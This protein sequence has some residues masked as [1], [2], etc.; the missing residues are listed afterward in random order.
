MNRIKRWTAFAAALLLLLPGSRGLAEVTAERKEDQ[1]H[2]VTEITWKD[3]QGNPASGPDGYTTVR[4][5]YDHNKTTEKYFD[6]DGFPYEMPGGYYGLAVT[7]D[8]FL[9]IVEYLGINGKLT[10]TRMGYAKTETRTFSFGPERYVLYYGEDGR[11]V[12][13]PSLGY[14]Q[15]ET[16]AT[17][18]T[19]TGR[20]YKDEKGNRVDIPAGYAAML[21]KM[22]RSKQ[23]IQI[24]YEH[25]DTTPAT[26]P[27]GWSRSEITRDGNNKGRITAIQYFD[28]Q[29]NLT[30][31][32]GFAREEYEYSKDGLVTVGR[33]N[34]LGSRIPFGGE[35]V[36]VARKMK[37]DLI[38]EETFLNEAGDPTELPAG[39]AGVRYTYNTAGQLE[40]TQYLDTA[41][42]K[43]TCH[44]G[45]SAIREA[46]DLN[47][48][49]LS[50]SYLDA[51]GAP[52]NH[53]IS[54]I[55]EERYEY[56]PDGRI[57]AVRQFDADGNPVNSVP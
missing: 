9:R 16:L 7:R 38:L 26:G 10:L 56:D 57:L 22:N 18:K 2:R 31:A 47:G 1:R 50:R 39:Y 12:T 14:A 20:I 19:L 42:A 3:E 8:S 48:Q 54:G 36:K 13:V 35:A 51:G 44:Q 33:F 37:G 41:G 45:Y 6:S 49:L 25:A 15:S 34:A 4:Y 5:E 53:N 17:G 27:D 28:E 29:G 21:K 32:G 24:W 40:L 23:V 46:W 30:D 43:T 11:L 52:V 55:S